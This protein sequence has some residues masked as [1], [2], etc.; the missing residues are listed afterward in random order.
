MP[1]KRF[2]QLWVRSTT[3]RRALVPA[4]R[5]NFPNFVIVIA[6]VQT[7]TLR[8][9]RR[10]CGPFGWY[11]VQRGLD[12]LHVIAVGAVYRQSYWDA[13]GLDQ[14]AA[15]DTLFGPVRRVFACLF[16]P[17]EVPW[18][19]TRPCSPRTSRCPLSRRRPT[20]RLPTWLERRQPRP[21]AGS[22]R[23]QWTRDRRAWHRVLS[24]GSQCATQTRWPPYRPD[25]GFAVGLR[26]SDAGCGV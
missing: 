25:R 26:Q 22:G 2:I 15:F 6:F 1:R 24:T 14:Q 20:A 8:L 12:Q 17:R 18:L 21:I 19:C 23:V 3:Q 7:Q 10:G 5:Y 16:P 9:L 4:F 11:A 13:I